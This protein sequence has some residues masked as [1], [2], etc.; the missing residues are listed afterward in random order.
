[1]LKLLPV[2]VLIALAIPASASAQ[3]TRTWV[4]GVGDDVNPCSRTAP[5]KTFAGAIS[6]T[7]TGG[8]IDVL[9]P[10]GFGALTITKSI[11]I[12]GGRFTAGM[13][14]SGGVNAINV[15]GAGAK[16]VLRNLDIEGHG[17]TLGLN[18]IRITNAAS[19]KMQNLQVSQFSRSGISVEPIAGVTTKVVVQNSSIYDNGG[20]AV[21]V[22]PAS[23]ATVN[24]TIRGTN[25]DGN[26]CG[27]VGTTAGMDA[28]FNFA[29]DCATAV[30]G[31]TFG[32]ASISMYRTSITDNTGA[33]V[34][35]RGA[36]TGFGL[37]ANELTRNQFGIRS[38][39][40]GGLFSFG[41]NLIAGNGTDGAP[42]A[43]V[44]PPK[45]VRAP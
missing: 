32:N 41:N 25:I 12:D 18:G 1:M 5:C 44:I 43:A 17:T 31:A 33:G 14:A 16:V 28:A 37:S 19:V 13:L 24:T 23:T 26:G 45:K 6:K 4:S 22:A 35:A 20:N 30:P 11:T 10:G 34:L 3:A 8:I 39:N 9:D 27:V 21:T 2:L 29:V 40:G 15:N 7:A 38:L 36:Q 42:T